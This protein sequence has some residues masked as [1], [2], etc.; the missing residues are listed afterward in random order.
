MKTGSRL[1]LSTWARFKSQE[2]SF[3]KAPIIGIVASVLAGQYAY[4]NGLE[5][6]VQAA[7]TFNAGLLGL[8]NPVEDAD[9]TRPYAYLNYVVFNSSYAKV[10]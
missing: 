2:A 5:N 1:Q 10:G 3:S 7:N 9:D 4:S 6:V 8:A